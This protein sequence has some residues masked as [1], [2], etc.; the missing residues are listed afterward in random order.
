[1]KPHRIATL[2]TFLAVLALA[3]GAA[4][5]HEPETSST[6]AA[7][8]SPAPTAAP[9]EAVAPAKLSDP[10]KVNSEAAPS[11]APAGMVWIPGGE[12][13]MGCDDP[14]MKDAQPPVRVYVDG[15]WM[16]RTEV[17]NEEFDEFVRATGYV[18][19]AEKT[20]DAKDFPGAPPENLVAGSVVFHPPDHPVAL[21]DHYVWWTYVPG[22]NWRHPSGPKSDLRGR[23]KHP[24]VHVAWQDAVAYATW[25]G[26]RLPTEAE[27]EFA[28]RGGHDGGKY[29]W[30]GD[31][32]KPGGKWAANIWQGHFPDKDRGED[33]FKGTAPVASFPVEGYGLYDMAGNVWEWC[34][35]WYRAD[36]YAQIANQGVVKNPAGPSDS[37]DP[38]EPSEKKR[39]NRGGSYLCSDEYCSRYVLGSRGKGEQDSGTSNLGFRC[40]KAP[41][42]AT[43]AASR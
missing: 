17:T 30:G 31:A 12:Y 24:V 36:A 25:A 6:A 15:F 19:V 39:V 20:P 14:T 21:N 22:A 11:P 1:M 3:G 18:T 16:D 26:K 41:V 27:W 23:M 5:H 43:Q 38:G 8:A 9:A 32:M 34:A 2:F 35:D 42:A 7:P 4:C 13:T 29:I 37:W 33:G 40:V 10:M 28:A